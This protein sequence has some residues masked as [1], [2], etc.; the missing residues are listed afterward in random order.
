[1]PYITYFSSF[2]E[3]NKIVNEVDVNDISNNMKTFNEKR[4]SLIYDKWNNL[5][6]KLEIK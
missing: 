3:L 1:M 4:K 6:N 5:I 2:E